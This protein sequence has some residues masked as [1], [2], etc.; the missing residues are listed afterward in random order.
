MGRRKWAEQEELR[1]GEIG[2]V[3]S[4]GFGFVGATGDPSEVACGAVGVTP[5]RRWVSR[6]WRRGPGE[7]QAA[8]WERG[9]GEPGGVWRPCRVSQ[10]SVFVFCFLT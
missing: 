3:T 6:E 5:V 1:G 2:Q 8:L 9:A 7:A 10:C 4:T